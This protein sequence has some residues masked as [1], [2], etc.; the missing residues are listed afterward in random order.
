MSFQL[1]KFSFILFL[2]L[3]IMLYPQPHNY[4]SVLLF[5]ALFLNRRPECHTLFKTWLY[6][7]FLQWPK[8]F[9]FFLSLF[10]F[11]IFIFLPL[12]TS[13]LFPEM[14]PLI[15]K[16]SIVHQVVHCY[17]II[18]NKQTN[19]VF[20]EPH[21]LFCI[22]LQIL[23]CPFWPVS[24]RPANKLPE[25]TETSTN[26][27]NF[28][29]NAR[30]VSYD[31]TFCNINTKPPTLEKG[32][33]PLCI[34]IF[35]KTQLFTW[36]AVTRSKKSTWHIVFMLRYDQKMIK[37]IAIEMKVEGPRLKIKDLNIDVTFP[38]LSPVAVL[39]I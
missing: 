12:S 32:K 16:P 22:R 10:S 3:T 20:R 29:S 11:L 6:W 36:E 30:H 14:Y 15:Q 35:F 26:F 28:P 17:S 21:V 2:F 27:L 38:Y 39:Q 7:E 18:T 23:R 33:K 1:G 4:S 13:F 37:Y 5:P 31:L 19:R 24:P 9:S 25:E 34:A 8:Y